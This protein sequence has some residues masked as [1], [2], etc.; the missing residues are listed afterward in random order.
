MVNGTGGL[1]S[2]QTTQSNANHLRYNILTKTK[3]FREYL[4]SCEPIE[5]RFSSATTNLQIGTAFVTIPQ[6]LVNLLNE[7]KRNCYNQFDCI[8]SISQIFNSRNKIIGAIA[9]DFQLIVYNRSTPRS[10]TNLNKMTITSNNSCYDDSN[11]KWETEND[12]NSENLPYK[13]V[14]QSKLNKNNANFLKFSGDSV[15]ETHFKMSDAIKIP[16]LPLSSTKVSNRNKSE[17]PLFNFLTGRPLSLS[18]ELEALQQMQSISPTESFIEALSSD[19]KCVVSPKKNIQ[20][21][22]EANNLIN[23]IDSMRIQVYEM[24]LTNAGLREILVKNG[25][26]SSS[27]ATGT[28]IIEGKLDSTL[29]KVQRG[30]HQTHHDIIRI[31][32]SHIEEAAS[33]EYFKIDFLQFQSNLFNFV[34]VFFFLS[35]AGVEFNKETIRQINCLKNETSTSDAAISLVLWYRDA[36]MKQSQIIGTTNIRLFDIIR[37]NEFT[38]TERLPI[39]TTTGDIILGFLSIKIELGCRGLHFGTEFLEAISLDFGNS[40]DFPDANYLIR[41]N[42]LNEKKH[43][44]PDLCYNCAKLREHE[45]KIDEMIL[46]ACVYD[47]QEDQTNGKVT[48]PSSSN[49]DAN[50]TN[51]LQNNENGVNDKINMAMLGLDEYGLVQSAKSDQ[52]DS[53]LSAN[54]R[55]IFYVGLINFDRSCQRIGDTFLVCRTFWTDNAIL[56]ENCRNNILNFLEVN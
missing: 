8:T 48:N 9:I 7:S 19:L 22:A 51:K 23:K 44:C 30:K 12:R 17:S 55:G 53:E 47:T 52:N 3:L 14:S 31:F 54:L 11:R 40:N 38:F 56:T 49:D 25:V 15:T 10:A 18:Q 5:I 46:S 26:T 32:S 29:V 16:K 41:S 24:T 2:V 36:Q 13:S 1:R 42:G 39:R 34:F 6:D 20:T 21:N 37:A 28:F 45:I 50:N 27:I 43:I 33:S 35:I 4:V